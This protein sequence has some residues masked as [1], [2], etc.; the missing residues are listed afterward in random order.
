M[1]RVQV[2]ETG[3][4]VAA[5]IVGSSGY[6]SLDA[7]ALELYESMRFLPA[8]SSGK[9]IASSATLPVKYKIEH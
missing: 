6:S 7:A 1:L 5:G 9:A 3:C 2:D 4:A 8:E